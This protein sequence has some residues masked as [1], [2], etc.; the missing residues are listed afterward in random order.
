MNMDFSKPAAH[1]AQK[2]ICRQFSADFYTVDWGLKLGISPNV[3][4]GLEPV[5]GFRHPAE[6][7]TSGWYI[8]A[9]EVRQSDEQFFEPLHQEHVVDWKPEIIEFLAL[10]P[11]WRFLIAGDYRDVW[12]D[13]SLLVLN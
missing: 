7:G 13:E 10:G 8:Y 2:A 9:G 4:T 1:E 12:Y 5:N 6:R 11:G 3:K